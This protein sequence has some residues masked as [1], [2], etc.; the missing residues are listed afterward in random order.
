MKRLLL[1]VGYPKAASTTLQN[2]L[3]MQLHKRQA[4]HFLGRAFES[5]FYGT[6]A[7]KREFKNWFRS[8]IQHHDADDSLGPLSDSVTNL[9]SEGLF[10]MNER[11][12]VEIAS[13]G[14]LRDFFAL[15]AEKLEVLLIMRA[16]ATLIPSYY[17]QNYLRMKRKSLSGF[18]DD[19]VRENWTG[20]GKIFNLHNV[21][22]AYASAFGEDNVHIVLF[23]DLA[24]DKQAFSSALASALNLPLDLIQ[25]SMGAD[26]L[27]QTKTDSGTVV[28]KKH[29]KRTM[30][31]L[32]IQ[33]LKM[34]S[35]KAADSLRI[36][37]PPASAAEKLAIFD[38]FKDSNLNLAEQFSMDK[39]R[40]RDYGYF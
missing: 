8:V 3:F 30:R 19:N 11:H 1:H 6:M 33:A 21:V 13:P 22:R 39:A 10:M 18:I 14:Q 27:N 31:Y 40:M 28:V 16:Q 38:A 26:H 2:G 37:L 4:I 25:E 17:G 35:S 15:K 34:V 32:A 12:N 36:R 7:S 5:R 9:L 20:E 29:G 23:E 24:S